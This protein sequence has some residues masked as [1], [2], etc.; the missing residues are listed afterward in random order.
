MAMRMW[1]Y[2]RRRA[3]MRVANAHTFVRSTRFVQCQL[4][5]HKMTSV[6]PDWCEVSVVCARRLKFI[7][8]FGIGYMHNTHHMNTRTL[9]CHTVVR[10]HLNTFGCCRWD[11]HNRIGRCWYWSRVQNT[12]QQRNILPYSIQQQQQPHQAKH[13]TKHKTK[14]SQKR[15]KIQPKKKG[16]NIHTKKYEIRSKKPFVSLPVLRPRVT[17]TKLVI[18]YFPRQFDRTKRWQLLPDCC[19]SRAAPMTDAPPLH[20]KTEHPYPVHIHMYPKKHRLER[21]HT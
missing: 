17:G 2:E 19:T 16:K 9:A 6:Y 21:K 14:A 1:E 7:T 13:N 15:Q 5:S 12:Y 18:E 4:I 8:S 20:T 10:N 3:T 11:I